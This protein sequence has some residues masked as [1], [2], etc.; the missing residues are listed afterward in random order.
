MAFRH[1]YAD[2]LGA[3]LT[4]LPTAARLASYWRQAEMFRPFLIRVARYLKKFS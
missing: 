2:L 1:N 3:K 4:I